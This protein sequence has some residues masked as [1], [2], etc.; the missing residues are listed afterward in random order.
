MTT[1]VNKVTRSV[2]TELF[3]VVS[4][5]SCIYLTNTKAVLVELAKRQGQT[6]LVLYQL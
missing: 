6:V 3:K 5:Y 4:C 1:C 2:F